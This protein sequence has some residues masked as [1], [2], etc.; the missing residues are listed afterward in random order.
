[1][2][3][4][5]LLANDGRSPRPATPADVAALLTTVKTLFAPHPFTPSTLNELKVRFGE[6]TI[7][8]EKDGATPA[9]STTVAVFVEMISARE[10]PANF[11][12]T[13]VR[14]SSGRKPG[15]DARAI[16]PFGLDRFCEYRAAFSALQLPTVQSVMVSNPNSAQ[17]QSK[18]DLLITP[19]EPHEPQPVQVKAMNGKPERTVA[20]IPTITRVMRLPLTELQQQLQ[21][22]LPS[23]FLLENKEDALS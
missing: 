15:P 22:I 18:I 2:H 21:L 12:E 11:R 9:T 1:M 6:W 8:A 14:I 4:V 13:L 19:K 20:H 16:H 10:I 23:R 3:C 7:C 5:T 17:D